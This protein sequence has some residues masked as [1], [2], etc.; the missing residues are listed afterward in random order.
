MG[1]YRQKKS[2]KPFGPWIVKF[3]HRWDI[4]KGKIVYTTCR[5]GHR[6]KAREIF[7]EKMAEWRRKCHPGSEPKKEYL[8][9][10]FVD[11]FC[12]CR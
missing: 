1:F 10:E 12:P 9:G 2:G 7:Q 6:W 4:K 11:W 5:A 3:P 8:F